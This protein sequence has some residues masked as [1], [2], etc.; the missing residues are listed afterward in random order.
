MTKRAQEHEKRTVQARE[1]LEDQRSDALRRTRELVAVSARALDDERE[2]I[3]QCAAQLW[4][5]AARNFVR[6]AI[7][8]AYPTPRPSA[9]TSG[10]LRR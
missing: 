10:S 4:S 5:A 3:E 2:Q 6:R 1:E 9:G 8:R 7:R